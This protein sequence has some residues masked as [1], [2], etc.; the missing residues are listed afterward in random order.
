MVP[1]KSRQQREVCCLGFLQKE[2]SCGAASLFTRW[3]VT[4]LVPELYMLPAERSDEM[5][6]WESITT[7]GTSDHRRLRNVSSSQNKMPEHCNERQEHS[8]L[9]RHCQVTQWGRRE[10]AGTWGS[11]RLWAWGHPIPLP[12][13]RFSAGETLNFHLF[14][15]QE[16]CE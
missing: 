11:Q 15:H 7:V 1:L 13:Y 2:N 14:P 12:A 5:D 8:T 10:F 3:L 16:G 6:K 4:Q 9:P